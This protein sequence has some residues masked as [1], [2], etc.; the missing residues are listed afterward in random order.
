V[1]PVDLYEKM[2]DLA[3]RTDARIEFVEGEAE[4]R[5]LDAMNGAGAFLKFT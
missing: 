1:A 4:T 3:R 2:V 5:L